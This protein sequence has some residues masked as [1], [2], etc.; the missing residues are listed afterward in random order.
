MALAMLRL[1]PVRWFLPLRRPVRHGPQPVTE[2]PSVSP[3]LIDIS[4]IKA[5]F[6]HIQGE[7]I[8]TQSMAKESPEKKQQQLDYLFIVF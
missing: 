7:Q 6:L 3:C 4:P 8:E 1:L 2:G 5:L